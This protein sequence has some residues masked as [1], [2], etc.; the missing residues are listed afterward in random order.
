MNKLHI[1]ITVL[2]I[3]FSMST[4]VDAKDTYRVNHWEALAE[5]PSTFV[6]VTKHDDGIWPTETV[7]YVAQSVPGNYWYGQ[8]ISRENIFNMD[9]Q[10]DAATLSPVDIRLQNLSGAFVKTITIQ[11]Q[12]IGIDKIQNDKYLNVKIYERNA[13]ATGFE[14]GV[15]M[16]QTNYAKLERYEGTYR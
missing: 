3:L 8:L 15:D 2:A 10:L 7:I 12:W 6:H 16:E 11:A 4:I 14:N 13:T 1:W 9:G 5:W